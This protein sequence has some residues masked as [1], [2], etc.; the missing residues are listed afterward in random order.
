MDEKMQAEALARFGFVKSANWRE[1]HGP[2][3]QT[4][5]LGPKLLDG[6]CVKINERDAEIFFE[7]KKMFS[8]NPD[9]GKILSLA[10][11]RKHMNEIINEAG[12]EK[13]ASEAALFFVY[14]GISGYLQNRV[15]IK[16]YETRER[17]Y[18]GNN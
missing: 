4:V 11:G 13:N 15:E 10:D 7:D 1:L 5:Y 16:L 18:E 12:M 9:G 17:H 8:V 14:L 6:V 2:E 3:G